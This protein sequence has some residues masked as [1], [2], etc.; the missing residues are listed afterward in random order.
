MSFINVQNL[1]KQFTVHQSGEGVLEGFKRLIIPLKKQVDAVK[2]VSFK[3]ERGETVGY[4]GANG[5]GKSTTIKML[6]GILVPTAGRIEINSLVPYEK[7]QENAKQIGVV[8]GQKSQLWW[9]LP[10]IDAFHLLG[11]IYRLDDRRLDENIQLFTEM[12]NLKDFLSTPVRKLSLGQKMRCELAA[13]LLH[14]PEILFL[15]EPTI[16]LDIVVKESIRCFLKQVNREKQT[17]ILL[18][19]H[20]LD[21]VEHLCERVIVIDQGTLIHDSGIQDLKKKFGHFKTA[22]FEV[23][24]MKKIQLPS[25]SRELKRD[26]NR[27]WIEFEADKIS[28]PHL[29][30]EI[31]KNCEVY[32]I[33]IS[34]MDIE[35]VVKRI[36]LN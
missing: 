26:Q 27:I 12:L 18:T 2:N 33:S 16:G 34:E 20:D 13:S 29:I 1:E 8:F 15:D 14:D 11:K 22:V 36:Y 25:F 28:A 31:M 17:T 5:A 7:R 32:D 24:C 3:I 23:D 21:D 9:D 19:T 4:L 35:E 30:A 6:T 10:P